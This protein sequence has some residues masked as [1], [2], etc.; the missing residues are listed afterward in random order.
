LSLQAYFTNNL[1]RI[2][3][4]INARCIATELSRQY[5]R[6]ESRQ[7]VSIY[8]DH[9]NYPSLEYVGGCRGDRVLVSL[10]CWLENNSY[11]DPIMLL[12]WPHYECYYS[13]PI[14]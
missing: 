7:A 13:D 1:Q 10:D 11:T 6:V 8:Y 2:S 5:W 14:R 3:A 9:T 12:L 4:A